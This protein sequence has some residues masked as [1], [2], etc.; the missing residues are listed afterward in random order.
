[1]SENIFNLRLASAEESQ[2][3]LTLRREKASRVDSKRTISGAISL[4]VLWA[5]FL[6][7]LQGCKSTILGSHGSDDKSFKMVARRRRA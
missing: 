7:R 6:R 1:M 2:M 5:K 3:K 4:M